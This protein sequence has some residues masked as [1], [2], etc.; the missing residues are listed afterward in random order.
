MSQT[1][2]CPFIGGKRLS[3]L[4]FADNLTLLAYSVQGMQTLVA[5][6]EIFFAE[7]GLTPNP[8]KCE[9]LAFQGTT[10]RRR[11]AKATWRVREVTREEQVSATYL[12]IHF[13]ASGK[14]VVQQ[15]LAVVKTRSALGRCKIVVKTVARENTA[16]AI[17]FFDTLVSSVSGLGVWGVTAPKVGE[18]D[19]VFVNFICWL[20]RFPRTTGAHFLLSSFARRCAKCDS[21]FLATV[22]LATATSTRNS[23][24]RDTVTNLRSNRL[25]ST[26]VTVVKSEID[27][28]GLSAQVFEQGAEFVAK[29][30]EFGVQ[31]SQYCHTLHLSTPSGSSSDQIV[32]RKPFGIFPF[33]FLTPPYRSRFLFAFLCSVWQYVDKS[34]CLLYPAYCSCCDQENSAYHVLF[35]CSLFRD[36]RDRF[37]VK[38]GRVFE[39]DVLYVSDRR[40]CCAVVDVGFELFRAVSSMSRGS[41]G[42][43]LGGGEPEDEASAASAD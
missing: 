1:V 15:Q 2:D 19:K 7:K 6:S 41:G 34:T 33:L 25:R 10:G 28:R 42:R 5:E 11:R 23:L 36:I 21:L 4:L 16:L 38:A 13:E 14:W 37:R 26:W 18:L 40:I 27:K 35:Q 17:N 9:F 12:G 3:S 22:Q 24:W 20:F 31:F 29:Q 8:A 30:K 39:F 32:R 43:H